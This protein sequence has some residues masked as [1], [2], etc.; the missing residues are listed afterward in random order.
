M[1]KAIHTKAYFGFQFQR[2]R[3]HNGKAE[4]TGSR[5][6]GRRMQRT[7]LF[8]CNLEAESELEVAK[9]SRPT[10]ETYFLCQGPER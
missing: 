5:H 3:V 1:T 7:F 10:P 9:L 2:V 6:G 4:A 8:N